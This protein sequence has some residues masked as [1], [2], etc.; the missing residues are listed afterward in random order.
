MTDAVILDMDES[1]EIKWTF[2]AM[3]KFGS[4]AREVLRKQKVEVRNERGQLLSIGQLGVGFMLSQ[5]LRIEEVM[6]AAVAATCGISHL[7]GKDGLSETSKAID[8]YIERG[9][10]MEDL[11]RA[12]F[13]AY[14]VASD[15]SSVQEWEANLVREA[16]TRRINAEKQEA[17]ME[18]A[19]L[20]LKGDQEKIM[21]LKGTSGN[22]PTSS[23]S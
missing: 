21:K 13:R 14:L 1:R 18:V 5:F 11:E 15:P 23:P 16:E 12:I 2:G 7:E 10:S 19:R 8:A 9:G 4:R 22:V 6:E 20:E 3:K 17:R